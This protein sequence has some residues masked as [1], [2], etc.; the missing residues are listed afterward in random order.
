LPRFHRYHL[1]IAALAIVL[2]FT[3]VHGSR[4][5]DNLSVAHWEDM[6]FMRHNISNVHS[7][8]DCF[9]ERPLWPGLYRPLT[10]NLYYYAG[11]VLFANRIE[12]HHGINIALYLM[13]AFLLYL[14]C[15]KLLPHWWAMVPPV[16]FASRFSHV[17]VVLNSCEVQT[18]FAVFFTLL[19]LKF[20]TSARR[21]AGDYYYVLS[22]IAYGLAL[23]SKETALVFP[24]ILVAYGLLHD[25]RR[26]WR[27]YVPPAGL[28]LI[29]IVLY[30]TV[31]RA[32]TDLEPT[33]FAYRWGAGH[34][35]A[36]YAAYLLTFVNLL[37]HRLGNLAMV[38]P[39][40]RVAGSGAAAFL[41]VLC[42]IACASYYI[43]RARNGGHGRTGRGALAFGFAF[44]L[45][46]LSP[47]VILESRLFMRYGY[48]GHAGLAISAGAL[49]YYLVT[50]IN[51]RYR[52]EA[53]DAGTPES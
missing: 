8:K 49:L 31:F 45:I 9:T 27:H 36:N 2:A 43:H 6:D 29:W 17:E 7:L 12:I 22:L 3:L 18:L 15:L 16:L 40:S 30:V 25:E 11:R 10:T 52:K 41:M 39:V 24:A 50:A 47:Y 26:A 13:N 34:I 20:F 33:G 23:L 21:G 28:A 53:E 1:P 37:T 32:V 46:A 5:R 19:A 42:A 14:I 48:A 44:F 4:A 51:G 38:R 35:F